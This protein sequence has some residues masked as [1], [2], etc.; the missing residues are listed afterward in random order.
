[1]INERVSVSSSAKEVVD[2]GLRK[3]MLKVYNYMTGGLVLTALTVYALIA[4]GWIA[5]FYNITPNGAD[6]S[7]LG[8]IVLFAPLVMVFF[9]GH[10]V[11]R[12]SL[13]QVQTMFWIFSVLMGASIAPIMLLYTGA[14]VTRVFLISASM[15]GAMSI[16]GYT[17][18]RDLTGIGSFMLMGLLGLIIASIVNIFWASSGLYYAISVIGVVIFVGLTAYDVQKIRNMYVEG[19]EDLSG[20]IAISGALSLYMDFINLFLYL[21][22]LLGDR[23]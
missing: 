3:Y 6:L 11:S 8:W 15:F 1:M 17:T 22:R 18:K 9:F 23:R 16:Y 12:G 2:E 10:A 20:R 19:D 4:T 14:S 5:N 21:L 7:A 13:L